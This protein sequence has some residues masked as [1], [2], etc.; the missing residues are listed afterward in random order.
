MADENQ[1][2]T[3]LEWY[4]DDIEKVTRENTAFRRV[5]YTSPNK[6]VQIVAMSLKPNE[7]IGLEIHSTVNQ[8]FRIEQGTGKLLLGKDQK[9]VKI[10]KDG[11]AINVPDGT[12]HNIINTSSTDV[13]KL[14]TIYTPA[15]HADKLV[16]ENKPIE[17]DGGKLSYIQLY[18]KYKNKYISLKQ[19]LK[20]KI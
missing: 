19:K 9:Y 15:Q 16:Q 13:L 18:S 1:H 12:W 20:T 2:Q 3:T 5:L 7:D 17:Q 8:F 11:S 10:I 6:K 14:Y 4:V